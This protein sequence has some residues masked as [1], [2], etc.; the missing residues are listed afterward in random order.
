MKVADLLEAR[1]QNWRELERLSTLLET[2]SRRKLGAETLTR[3]AALYRSACADLALADAYQLPPNTVAY[4]HQLVGKAHNQLYRTRGFDVARWA[5]KLVFEVPQQLFH[6]NALRLAFVLFWGIFL[7]AMLRAYTTP[8]FIEE[9]LDKETISGLED[10]Y[11]EPVPYDINERAAMQG[12]YIQHNATI[13]I[14]CFAFGV[15]LLGIGGLFELVG[16]AFSLGAMFGHMATVPQKVNFFN[17][18]TAH[19]PFELTAIVLTAA[20]GMRVGFSLVFTRGMTRIDSLRRAAEES[21]T[22]LSVGVLL[23][24]GAAAIEAFISPSP[25]PYWVKAFVGVLTSGM[26]M[27]YFVMLGYPRSAAPHAP[28][29]AA[30]PL[31]GVD[32]KPFPPRA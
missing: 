27:F 26:L 14:R 6:D 29:S 24:I 28:T 15:C 17:F 16:N 10:M 5:H 23:F 22:P 25:L 8:G 31:R 11:A 19:G 3:F 18:V 21:V 30:D 1:H 32:T 12:L 20:A 2:R 13:G 9:V 7:A 4:L